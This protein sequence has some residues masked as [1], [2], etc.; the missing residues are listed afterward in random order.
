MIGMPQLEE[1]GGQ[2]RTPSRLDLAIRKSAI[3]GVDVLAI[4]MGR[5]AWLK[6][7]LFCV[8]STCLLPEVL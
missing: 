6:R 5:E 2:L 7:W 8:V 3:D 4:G 1:V